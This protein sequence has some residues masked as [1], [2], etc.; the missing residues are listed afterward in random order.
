MWQNVP[1][2]SY[3]IRRVPLVGVSRWAICQRPRGFEKYQDKSDSASAL[4]NKV[5]R[6]N[7]LMPSDEHTNYSLQHSFQ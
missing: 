7:G 5:M 1:G 2:S 3:S 4:I 6:N